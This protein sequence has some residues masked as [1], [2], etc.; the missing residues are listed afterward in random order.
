MRPPDLGYLLRALTELS[1]DI[2]AL[3][4]DPTSDE[5]AVAVRGR[6][7]A[8]GALLE[9]AL[10]FAERGLLLA[11]LA[12]AEPAI[13]SLL[14]AALVYEEELEDL[15]SAAELYKAILELRADHRRA[16]V[17]LGLLLHDLG[18]WHDLIAIYRR[19]LEQS[20]DDGERTTLHLYAAE[21]LS[22]KLGDDGAAFGELLKAARLAPK[23]L[24]II[25]RLE[26]L[27]E[28]T[29]RVSEVAVVI[30][31]LLL[32]QEDPRV[33][34]ALSLRL[35]ELHLGPLDEPQRALAYL[36]SALLDD[37]GNPELIMEVEDV[38]RERAR[39]DELAEILEEA[40]RDRRVGSQRIRLEREL[41]RIYELELG[42]L[43]RA[44]SAMSS[45]ARSAPE[46]RELL[47][48]VMRLGLLTGDMATV[49]QTFSDVSSTTEN[50]LLRT[51]ARLKLGHLYAG[52]LGRPADAIDV[53]WAILEDDPGHREARRR[54]MPLHERRGE[55]GPICR[56]LELEAQRVEGR[57][58]AEAWR[59]V[60]TIRRDRLDDP[61]G[62]V[63]AWRRLLELEPGDSEALSQV[64][65]LPPPSAVPPPA[66]PPE[67]EDPDIAELADR[68][69]GSA[70]EVRQDDDPTDFDGQGFGPE[71]ET[72]FAATPPKGPPPPPPPDDPAELELASGSASEEVAAQAVPMGFDLARASEEVSAAQIEAE[73]P[74]IP[75]LLGEIDGMMDDPALDPAPSLAPPSLAAKKLEAELDERIV[76]LQQE[77]QDATRHG[78]RARQIEILEQI[79][80]AHERLGHD[81]R[82]FFSAIRLIEL[83]PRADRV[84]DTIKLGRKAKSYTLLIATIEK[85]TAQLGSA[86][87]LQFGR[88]LAEVELEDLR[89]VG[90]AVTRLGALSRMAPDDHALFERWTIILDVSRRYAELVGVLR[91]RALGTMGTP[92]ALAMVRRAAQIAE[93][94]LEDPRAA[95]EVLAAYLA[96]APERDDLRQDAAELLE[97][98]GAWRELVL[99][100]EGGI[101]RL[102]GSERV[103]VRL[104]IARVYL[105]RLQDPGAAEAALRLGL[106]ERARD[107]EILS[108][109]EELYE[110]RES[111]AELVDILQRRLDVVRGARGRN[112][113][114]RKIASVAE[115]HLGKVELALDV[116]G[117]AVRDDRL[118]LDALHDLERLRRDRGDWDG[119]R[120]VLV[121][122][123]RALEDPKER[124]GVLVSIAAINADAHGDLDAAAASLRD[125]LAIAPASTE[126]LDYLATIEDRRGDYLSAASAL[127]RLAELVEGA[128]R[129]KVFVRI[130]RLIERRLEDTD[131]AT[132]EYQ[133]AYDADPHCLDAILALLRIRELEENYAQ[134]GEL[135]ARAATLTDDERDK[136][137]LWRRAAQIFHVRIGD[138]L[139]ALEYY[140]RALALDPEDL[141][142]TATLGELLFARQDPERAYPHLRRAADGLSDPERTAYLYNAAGQAAERSNKREEAISC[143]ESALARSPRAVEPLRRLSMLLERSE[144][145]PRVYELCASLILHHETDLPPAERAQVFM[146]MARAKRASKELDAATRLARKAHQLAESSLEPLALLADV[147]AENGESFE[148]AEALKKVAQLQ[149][150][151]AERKVALY[152]AAVL[153]AEGADDLARASAML[154]EAQAFVPEDIEV[155]ELLSTY[156]ERLGDGRGASTA[157]TVPARLLGGRA[158]AEL[159]LRAARISAGLA[160]DRVASK[161][162]LF[163]VLEVVPT[164]KDALFDLAVMLEF[165]GEIEALAKVL[166][167]SAAAFLDDPSTARDAPELDRKAAARRLLDDALRLYRVRLRDPERALAALR[168]LL[169]LAPED[170]VYREDFAR[171][172]D[173]AA[174][175]DP[176]APDALVR[177]AIGAWAQIVESHPGFVEG[178]R[179]LS[180]LQARAGEVALARLADELLAALG[181]AEAGARTGG[182]P[183]PNGDTR[184]EGEPAGPRTVVQRMKIEIPV[185]PGE[186]SMF[187]PLAEGLGFAP[188]RALH[189]VLPEPKPKK[190]DLAGAA[191]LGIHVTRP[192]EHAASVLG[193]EVPPVYVRDDAPAPV[194]PALVLD[195]PALIVSV[196]LSSKLSREELR[197]A[198]GRALSLLRPRALAL[199]TIPLELLRDG[200]VGLAKPPIPPETLFAD[201]KR[202]KKLGRALEKAL[203][204]TERVRLAEELGRWL[205]HPERSSL[206]V[207]RAAVLRTAERSGLVASGSVLAAVGALRGMNDG[208]VDRAWHVPL[209]EYASTRAFAEIVRRLG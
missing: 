10:A 144:D 207:E 87:E 145:W 202:S 37:G 82:A 173:R 26:K 36:R 203:P 56:L 80:R 133:T 57:A 105:E 199:A 156:R 195:Q 158:R 110:A 159:L 111:W 137:A 200:L 152:R 9:Y 154:A 187:A 182:K 181:D 79:V 46:D 68:V 107:P 21:I 172:L 1:E 91:D 58:A 77:L 104:R 146:R 90:A 129:A 132:T 171:L 147:L 2:E 54:L 50:A 69:G 53:Y 92:E 184:R 63:E 119:V 180:V 55:H 35:A 114:R 126:A 122:R 185:H 118:D 136:A 157:L 40:V 209:I 18:R 73:A 130:G 83:D 34:A 65:L 84:E 66:P 62:A 155:A 139:R 71:S 60:A 22:E 164:Q 59:R 140:G 33:R 4:R 174:E 196:A 28:R 45:A 89:D 81:D 120:E 208:R 175:R 16:L 134:A 198:I 12:L 128:P 112:A 178:L 169:A 11:D 115:Q 135:A 6:A 14:E 15:S 176:R 47:D 23:N 7:R 20:S 177:E 75:E 113:I 151:P 190:R 24:R 121:L 42:D 85:I 124:A 101:D 103:A 17:A 188:L 64:P 131:A 19:R 189:D 141:A 78:D 8:E 192:L 191:G 148:A 149:R 165:D 168:K 25:S 193:L 153:L 98:A 205:A 138:E 163:E 86:A 106:A 27:G 67:P 100:L 96:E 5:A 70:V 116:L 161:Q 38:F 108:L 160:R 197:F 142:T 48:E 166:E 179:R 29:G 201:P 49:A 41:A 162:L 99:L 30:G 204:P 61:A 150:T 127:R 13:E 76:A 74:A 32:H 31:D 97:K 206:A 3:R 72:H 51:Y 186:A 143:Y 94:N 125:A 170:P 44:L 39:F 43:Q 117:D 95:A 123:S 52:T 93:V 109:L 102:E 183:G 194:L 167:R 88:M